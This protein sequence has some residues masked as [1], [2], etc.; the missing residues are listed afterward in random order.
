MA[1]GENY[2]V[3]SADCHGGANVADYRPYLQT[4]YHDDFDQQRSR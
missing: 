1:P 2:V 4:Q 3:I